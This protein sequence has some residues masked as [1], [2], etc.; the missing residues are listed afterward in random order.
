MTS[1]RLATER[2]CSW[3][4]LARKAGNVCPEREYADL[5][6]DDFLNSAAAIAPVLEQAPQT[7][8]G[9]TILRAIQATRRVVTTNTNLGIVLLLAPLATASL[10]APLHEGLAEVLAKTTVADARDAYTAIRL[11]NPGGLG[12]AASQ[13]VAG[14]PTLTLH[15][16]MALAPDRDDIALQYVTDFQLVFESAD[17]LARHAKEFGNI[18]RAIVA[19]HLDLLASRIDSLITRKLGA[20]ESRKVQEAA[21]SVSEAGDLATPAAAK[22]YREFD[23]MLRAA[24]HARNPGTTADLI[25]AALFVALRGGLISTE[26]PFAWPEHPFG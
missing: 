13:D 16:A 20:L 18:E 14:E 3:E 11:A 7:S 8:L 10:N 22:A 6:V 2:A 4:V 5:T 9:Q 19:T 17:N 23:A 15:D 1:T 24:N 12:S 26:L 21:M 25:A